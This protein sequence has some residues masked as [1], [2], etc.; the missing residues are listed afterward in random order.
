MRFYIFCYFL[1]LS[2]SAIGQQSIYQKID[3]ILK[4]Q[5]SSAPSPGLTIGVVKNGQLVYHNSEGL[6]NLDHE[7]P[8]NDSS[9]FSLASVTKQFTAACIALLEKKGQLSIHDDVRKFIPELTL[10]ADTIRIQHLLNHTSG[11]RN[12]NV[13]LDLAGFDYEHQG[14]TN[15]MIQQLMFHQKGVNNRPGDKMLYSNT[16]YVLLALIIERVAKMPLHKFAKKEL[17]IPLGMHQT[18]YAH[19]LQAVTKNKAYSYYKE[20]EHYKQPKSLTLCVGAGGV[21][22][23][24]EDLARWAQIF[25]DK[26]H[27]FYHLSSFI[28]QLDSL[29]NGEKMQHARGMFV[30]PYKNQ[31][32]FNH[33]GRDRGMRAQ[34]LSV[35]ALQIT[36]IVFAN[37]ATINAVEVSYSILDLWLEQEHQDQKE[38]TPPLPKNKN[39]QRFVGS[40]QELNSDLGMD[41]SSERDTLYAK[42]SFGRTSVPLSM[43]ADGSFTRRDNAAVQYTFLSKGEAEADLL[44]DFG[45]AI[46]YFEKVVLAPNP[47]Q[48]LQD[49]V[50]QYYSKELAVQYELNLLDG[51]LVLHYPNNRNLVLQEGVKDVFGANRRTKYS[52]QRAP[53]G[54]VVS[55]LV[56]SEGTV[57]DI[58]FEKRPFIKH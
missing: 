18:F 23:T 14:Y 5:V 57:K 42:S 31:L 2:I 58:L 34:F 56:A 45:G 1:V 39:L 36:V 3:S 50:G 15:K 22:S 52:F 21:N 53:N 11:L 38:P 24:I 44:V 8:F 47:N 10:F 27:P 41:I 4:K 33:S 48:N 30:T 6:M 51:E 28:T 32:T 49:Y 25:L 29:N 12:H 16:N 35:P 54:Q 19:D 7:V 43:I 20:G 55:F 9:V 37:D 17:F 13:L 46:F 26:T 40:Y